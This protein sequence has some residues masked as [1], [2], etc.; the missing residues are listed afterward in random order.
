MPENSEND[1]ADWDFFNSEEENRE[2]LEACKNLIL[3]EWIRQ[4]PGTRPTWWWST[5]APEKARQRLRG[6]GIRPMST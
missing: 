2:I 5:S 1:L 3:E 6:T 4:R